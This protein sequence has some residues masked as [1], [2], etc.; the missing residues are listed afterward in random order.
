MGSILPYSTLKIVINELKQQGSTVVLNRGGYDIFDAGHAVYL[1]EC[2]K[3]GDILVVG[4]ESDM[5]I[6]MHK[7]EM[8]P[9]VPIKQRMDVL[10]AISVVDFVFEIEDE[11]Y[12]DADF[13]RIYR[14]LK[15]SVVTYGRK[16]SGRA[17][18]EA[19]IPSFPDIRFCVID[20]E[21]SEL[22]PTVRIMDSM[23]NS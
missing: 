22:Q 18:I 19:D 9:L 15:P 11:D 14:E 17:M 8:Y 23:L 10:T 2:K 1:R 16:F 4:C 20:H 21:Y 5:R 6:R 13:N 3:L 12:K 7:N